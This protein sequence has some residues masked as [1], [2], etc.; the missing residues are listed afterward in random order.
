[1]SENKEWDEILNQLCD[2]LDRTHGPAGLFAV[3]LYDA[4]AADVGRRLSPHK[5]TI[6]KAHFVWSVGV[7]LYERKRFSDAIDPLM[8]AAALY[9]SV[10]G[11]ERNEGLYKCYG[12][13]TYCYSE[14]NDI[15]NTQLWTNKTLEI[16]KVVRGQRDSALSSELLDGRNADFWWKS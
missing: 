7:E 2:Y 14:M 16:E 5:A 9:E 8:T 13:I 4:L 1:M 6:E 15:E 12:Y 10:P 11:K 3:K